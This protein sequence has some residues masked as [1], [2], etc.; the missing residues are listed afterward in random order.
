M[1]R[2]YEVHVPSYRGTAT[3]GWERP[4]P[5]CEPTL[6]ALAEHYLLSESGFPPD[7]ADDLAL[8]VVDAEGRLH[9]SALIRA[10]RELRERDDLTVSTT[11]TGIDVVS[12]LLDRTF[13]GERDA[14]RS[15][16]EARLAELN[17][18]AVEDRPERDEAGDE[19]GRSQTDEEREEPP[20]R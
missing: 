4:P 3:A 9:E 2:S 12:G 5:D 16:A 10:R 19:S 18:P 1:I 17:E 8:P 7:S 20:Q 6:Q 11:S 14:S 13:R 15:E